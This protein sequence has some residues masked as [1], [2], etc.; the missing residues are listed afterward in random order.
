[1]LH[2]NVSPDIIEEKY[3][4]FESM[5]PDDLVL[6]GQDYL[7]NDLQDRIRYGRKETHP[8][9]STKWTKL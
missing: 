4:K 2:W 9:F 6:Y 5:V 8:R 1:M 7:A 3:L